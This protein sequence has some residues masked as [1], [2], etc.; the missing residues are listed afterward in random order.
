MYCGVSGSLCASTRC[1]H[2]IPAYVRRMSA[3]SRV[4]PFSHERRLIP[5]SLVRVLASTS[6]LGSVLK[7]LFKAIDLLH[8]DLYLAFLPGLDTLRLPGRFQCHQFCEYQVAQIPSWQTL[9]V[10]MPRP[11]VCSSL[12]GAGYPEAAYYL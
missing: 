1:Y 3:R 2:F 8:S 4:S 12:A 11:L 5:D 9:Q 7:T 6:S 10:L